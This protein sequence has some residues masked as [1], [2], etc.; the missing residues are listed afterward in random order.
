MDGSTSGGAIMFNNLSNLGNLMRD[1]GKIREAVEKA[2][3]A[4]GKVLVEGTAGGGAVTA[5]ADGHLN[6]VSLRIDP[7]LLADGDVELLE[8]LAMAAA[9]QALARAKEVAANSMAEGLPMM[10]G[11][12][13]LFGQG[14]GGA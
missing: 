8:E 4:L 10:S 6:L 2:R 5:K 1:A 11:L 14:G 12:G 9:N 3:D 13:N 7:K